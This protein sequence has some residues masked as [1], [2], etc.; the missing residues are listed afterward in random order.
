MVSGEWLVA[1]GQWVR[2]DISQTLWCGL[3]VQGAFDCGFAS[4][5]R[6]EIL[7]QDDSVLVMDRDDE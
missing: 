4:R 7:A 5:S 1:S 3:G 6:S 2:E